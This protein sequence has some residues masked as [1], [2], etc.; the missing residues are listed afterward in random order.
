MSQDPNSRKTMIYKNVLAW[1]GLEKLYLDEE[2]ADVFFVFKING[3]AHRIPA[4]KAI[5]A[6]TSPAF[7]AMFYGSMKQ[8][9]DIPIVDATPEVFREFLQN[10]YRSTVKVTIENIPEVIHL[11]KKYLVDEAL[12]ACAEL[13]KSTLNPQNVCWGYEM[14]ILFEQ[15]QLQQF[16]EQMISE[17]AEAIFRSNDFLNCKPNLLRRILQ[18]DSL[19]CDE[20]VV[21]NGCLRWAENVCLRKGLDRT[22]GGNLRVVLGDMFFEIRFGNMAIEKATDCY[23]SHKGLISLAEYKH[24]CDMITTGNHSAGEFNPNP[25]TGIAS[26]QPDILVCDRIDWTQPNYSHSISLYDHDKTRFTSNC[27][28]HLIKIESI[29][30]I[31]KVNWK[32]DG[33]PEAFKCLYVRISDRCNNQVTEVK[34]KP[35]PYSDNIIE[36]SSSFT[37]KPDVTYE[38]DIIFKSCTVEFAL[39]A[40]KSEVK[41]NGG[42]VVE[43]HNDLVSSAHQGLLTRFHFWKPPS[44]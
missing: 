6:A 23:T 35:S 31:Q 33:T 15:D 19:E 11:S 9:G 8:N 12:N 25:R 40:H 41:M 20:T 44:K 16:C 5:L 2:T 37:V 10:F 18:L 36:F 7:H 38:I 32:N 29:G 1:R 30:L 27:L 24:I 26:K 21:F 14:A 39:H 4:H 42:A 43:F 13:C 17:N 3:E 22:D 34:W 28:L